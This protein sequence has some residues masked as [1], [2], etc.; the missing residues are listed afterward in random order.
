MLSDTAFTK[1]QTLVFEATLHPIFPVLSNVVPGVGSSSRVEQIVHGGSC[2]GSR[3]D[4]SDD[5]ASCRS[6]L[7]A[8]IGRFPSGHSLYSMPFEPPI[9]YPASENG[10]ALTNRPILLARIC[11]WCGG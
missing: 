11:G 1:L 3:R 7:F 9:G 6:P 4:L 8:G 2:E 5:L 10:P